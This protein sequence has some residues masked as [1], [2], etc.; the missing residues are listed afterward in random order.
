MDS[1]CRSVTLSELTE[2]NAVQTS[3]GQSALALGA[4]GGDG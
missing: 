3:E 4:A 1:S 2:L